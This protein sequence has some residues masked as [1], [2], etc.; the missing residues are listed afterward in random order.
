MEKKKEY[1]LQ[2]L[3]VVWKPEICIHYANCVKALPGVFKPKE[4]PWIQM[5]NT[6]VEAVMSAVDKCP[7]GALSYYRSNKE[8]AVAKV[9]ENQ[10]SVKV[11]LI[12]QGPVIVLSTVEITHPDGSVE[13]KERRASFCRCGKSEKYPYCDG[14]HKK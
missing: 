11:N 10:E 7:S 4:Q 6:T 1:T 5:D 13:L 3:T 14:T 8:A 9:D 2:D 12:D